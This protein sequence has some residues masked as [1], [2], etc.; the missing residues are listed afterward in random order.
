LHLERT[1]INYIFIYA[2]LIG[3]IG[4]SLPLGTAAVFN[5]LSNGAMYSSTYLLITVI[6]IGIVVG[7]VLL[8]AQL[9]FVT[10]IFNKYKSNSL[11]T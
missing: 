5:L 2:I 9:A 8:I 6:L 1:T 10:G 3:I 11:L 7:G 4:L